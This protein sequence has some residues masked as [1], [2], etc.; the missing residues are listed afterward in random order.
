MDKKEFAFGRKNFILLGISMAVVV[1][2]FLLMSGGGSTNEAYNEDIF[3]TRRITIAPIV[4]LVGFL[5]MIY[6]V[7]YKPKD[8]AS[9]DTQQKPE[10]QSVVTEGGKA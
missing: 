3:S 1:L 7:V 5:S 2:G 8:E 4:C 9:S 6:A 10:Q